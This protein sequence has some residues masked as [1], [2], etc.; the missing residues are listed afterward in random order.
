MPS[1]FLGYL[2]AEFFNSQAMKDIDDDGDGEFM[3]QSLKD[4]NIL[5]VTVFIVNVIMSV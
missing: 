4:S 1:G 5:T 2:Y 3:N